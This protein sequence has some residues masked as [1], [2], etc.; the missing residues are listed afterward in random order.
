MNDKYNVRFHLLL[1]LEWMAIA[2]ILRLTN[3]GEKPP[4]ADEF[5]TL[6]FSL[7]RGFRTVPLDQAI[8]SDT[9]LAPLKTDPVTDVSAVI[10]HLMS[11]T[12]HPPVYFMLNHLW[13]QLFPGELVSLWGARSLSAMLGIISIPAIFGFSW[14]AFRSVKVGHLAAV[15]MAVSPYGIY[16]AQ[17]ARH[18]TLAI[19]LIIASLSCLIIATRA[20]KSQNC[21]PTWLIL[22]WVGLNSLGMAVHYFFILVIAA[23]TLVIFYLIIRHRNYPHWRRLGATAAGTAIGVVVWLPVWQNIPGSKLTRWIYH[24]H[25]FGDFLAPVARILAWTTTMLF[26]VPVEGQTLPVII[27]SL[28]AV[29]FLLFFTVRLFIKGIKISP[30]GFPIAVL[31]GFLLGEI[32]LILGLTYGLGIDLTLVARYQFVYFPAAIAL[33]ASSFAS[34]WHPPTH[35]HTH[36]PT[37]TPTLKGGA[38]GTKPAGAGFLSQRG[39]AI[40]LLAGLIGGLTV[41]TNLAYQKPDRPDLVVADILETSNLEVPILIATVHKTHEQT[42]EMMGLAWELTHLN[43]SGRP[44]TDRQ[45]HAR[46]NFLLAHKEDDPLVA[47]QTLQQTLDKLPKP[48]ELWVVNFSAS[49]KIKAQGCIKDKTSIARVAGY[50]YRRYHCSAS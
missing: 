40:I 47:T 19:L 3:L 23:E 39:V 28:L 10:R 17:D 5:S 38:T 20:V 11:E 24:S 31:G 12:N 1:L 15:L 22:T 34:F 27:I 37:H 46:I 21:C 48:L 8:A 50:R 4:W 44:R 42:G 16:L 29:L 43:F 14:L 36:T 2:A 45:V 26:M 25:S 6:I 9:L 13:L 7:G 30:H 33:L 32:A 35:T 18:Y 41:V 49:V